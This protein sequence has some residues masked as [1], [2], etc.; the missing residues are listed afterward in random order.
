MSTIRLFETEQLAHQAAAKLREGGFRPA[1]ISVIAPMAGREAAI[2]EAAV[3]AG[4]I[5][6][7]HANVCREALQRGRHVLSVETPFG[8]E[9]DAI[10]ILEDSGAVDTGSLPA[11]LPDDAAPLSD[12]LGI[13]VLSQSRTTT[14]L[15]RREYIFP[16]WLGLGLSSKKA[17]P[18]SSMFGMKTLSKEKR[19]WNSSF[20]LPLLTKSSGPTFGFKALTKEKRPWTSSFGFPLLSKNSAPLSSM[21]GIRLLSRRDDD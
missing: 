10:D 6:G 16:S 5:P 19:P 12:L 2:V 8:F 15:A 14:Q 21:F 9:Q 13:P 18:L 7:N 17:A 20:G 4:T 11:Y 3:E 1:T